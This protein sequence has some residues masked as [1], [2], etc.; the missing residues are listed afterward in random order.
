[1]TNQNQVY[2][3]TS[4]NETQSPIH[5]LLIDDN[6]IDNFINRKIL[7]YYGAF[8]VT[9]FNS[10]CLALEHLVD[11][12]IKYHYIF[13]DLIMPVMDGF[14]FIEQ[15]IKMQLNIGQGTLV[16]VSAS[17]NPLDLIMAKRLTINF[18]EKPL[19]LEKLLLL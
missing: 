6:S 10:A 19:T 8:S 15:F 13:V 3:T 9:V 1:M 18:I 14:T 7:E 5:V 2:C 17:L 12:E 16:I 4:T 11:T